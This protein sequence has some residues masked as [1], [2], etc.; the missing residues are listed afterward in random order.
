MIIPNYR[1]SANPAFPDRH[2]V[3]HPTHTH[4]VAAALCMFVTTCPEWQDIGNVV[5]AGH[6]CG[7]HILSHI[8]FT[9]PFDDSPATA[10]P[11]AALRPSLDHLIGR[12]HAVAF[13][14]GITSVRALAREYP[15]YAFFIEAAFGVDPHA[16]WEGADAFTEERAVSRQQAAAALQALRKIVIAH[17]SADELLTPAQGKLFRD[18]LARNGFADVLEWDEQTLQGTHDGCLHD[19]GVGELL[20]R[21]LA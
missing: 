9:L 10:T 3:A 7:A 17:A 1:L 19:K 6:S 18:H 12:T 4:D 2:A 8:L 11:P 20:Y 15:G 13:L 5:L 16:R 14:D 21:L